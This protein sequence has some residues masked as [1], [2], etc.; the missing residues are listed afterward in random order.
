MYVSPQMMKQILKFMVMVAVGLTYVGCSS[1]EDDPDP[2]PSC[3]DNDV[4][5]TVL[6]YAVNKSSLAYNFRDDSEEMLKAMENIDTSKFRLLLYRTDSESE[7]GLYEARKA[8]SGGFVFVKRKGYKRDVTSTHPDRIGAVVDDALALF[9]KSAYDLVFWGHGM[10]WR[11]DFSDHEVPEIK[12]KGYGGEYNPS[13]SNLDW[14]G[15][16]ELA[17]AIPDH[18]FGTIWFDCCYMTGIEVV[19]QM[20]DKCDTFVGYPTEVWEDGMQYDE[21]LPY[22]LRDTPDVVGGAKAFFDHYCNDNDPVTVA[23]IDMAKIENVAESARMALMTG[24]SRPSAASL[25]NYSRSRSWPFYDFR[26]FFTSTAVING[27]REAAEAVERAVSDAVVYSAAYSTDFNRRPWN[28]SDISGLSTHFYR[29]LAT[30]SE[31]Y[32]RSLDWYK[33]VFDTF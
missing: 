9:P 8:E 5:R 15:I 18:K 13:G 2:G 32:Y 12:P 26:Q 25:L 24:E 23:V 21:V 11:P 27:S 19:Y 10:S 30:D 7:C 6:V 16:D 4:R 22:L 3:D 31:K 17:D 29:G 1:P 14:T 20:R 28:V 33:R